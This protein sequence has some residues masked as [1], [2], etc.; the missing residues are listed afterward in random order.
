MK[1][2]ALKVAVLGV[3]LIVGILLA[4][5]LFPSPVC[6]R[7]DTTRAY[8]TCSV[9]GVYKTD[10]YV[11]DGNPPALPPVDMPCPECGQPASADSAN[12]ENP[13]CYARFYYAP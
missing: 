8:Y 9:H 5:Q 2:T 6:S 1:R 7:T 3:L 10:C 4:D 11:P 12:C 13:A